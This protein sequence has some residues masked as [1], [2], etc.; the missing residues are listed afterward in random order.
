M[1]QPRREWE[2]IMTQQAE[3]QKK[4]DIPLWL[5]IA[6]VVLGVGIAGWFVWSQVS[7]FWTG[8]SGVF[9]IQGVDPN[10]G[11]GGNPG[12]VRRAPVAVRQPAVR[13]I[14]DTNW[15]VRSGIF[16]LTA[17]KEGDALKIGI[18]AGSAQILPKDSQWV[19][20][21]R[22]RLTA[23]AAKEIG[24]N[25]QQ[26]KAFKALPTS[27]T[28]N[29]N[30]APDQLKAMTDLFEKY[31]AASDSEKDPID[32]LIAAE[33][34]KTGKAL[35]PTAKTQLQEKYDAFRKTVTDEQWEKLKGLGTSTPAAAPAQ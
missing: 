34:D 19:L 9:T 11:A 1:L 17:K 16:S 10:A 13:Q 23:D 32:R 25:D 21:A 8:P 26:V 15:R 35:L 18:L 14:N 29:L 2:R 6:L 12:M 27:L 3:V 20:M 5:G 7:N 4:R 30:P 33:L 22:G 28:V 31:I 24:L